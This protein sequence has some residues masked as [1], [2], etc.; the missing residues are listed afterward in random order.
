MEIPSHLGGGY[1]AMGSMHVYSQFFCQYMCLFTYSFRQELLIQDHWPLFMP[2]LLGLVEHESIEVKTRGLNILAL[3][4]GKCPDRVLQNTGIGRVFADVAFPLLLS[5]PSVTPEVQ[6]I[7]ILAPA[8]D[9]L[10]K[11]AESTGSSD[12]TG[13]RRLLDKILRDGILAGHFHASQH[14]RIIQILMQQTTSVVNSL[15]IYTT[16]HL[17]VRHYLYLKMF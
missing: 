17:T 3:F 10:I 5:L 7:S 6:S 9:V 8:Y 16:K 4:V 14:T 1:R 11:L 13:R 12:N 15:G 2:V